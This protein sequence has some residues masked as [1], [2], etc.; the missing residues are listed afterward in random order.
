MFSLNLLCYSFIIIV[1]LWY[2]IF[3][4]YSCVDFLTNIHVWCFL[5][6]Q[7]S[8]CLMSSSLIRNEED[9]ISIVLLGCNSFCH[10]SNSLSLLYSVSHSLKSLS[11]NK[12]VKVLICKNCHR[13]QFSLV[14]KSA[15]LMRSLFI[16][17]SFSC[18][19]KYFHLH[20]PVIQKTHQ[21]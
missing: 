8:S 16:W 2:S 6:Y 1:S 10:N 20:F 5:L 21:P 9:S 7:G 12:S 4:V 19:W 14:I 13:V 11:L 15:I 18:F 3:Y 17:C